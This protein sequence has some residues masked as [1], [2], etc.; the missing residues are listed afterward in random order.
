MATH[1]VDPP[2][3]GVDKYGL[4]DSEI[5][6][7]LAFSRRLIALDLVREVMSRI[8]D[9]G[10]RWIEITGPRQLVIRK[11]AGLYAA[12]LGGGRTV[13]ADRDLDGVLAR[14]ERLLVRSVPI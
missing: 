3:Y 1:V 13:I 14:A 12:L 7:V 2:E 11:A 9:G 5:Q 10:R 8:D 4:T 6:T